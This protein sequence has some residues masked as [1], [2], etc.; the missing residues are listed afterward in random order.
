M[1]KSDSFSKFVRTYG[2]DETKA[3]QL[4]AEAG[5]TD[6]PHQ[7]PG[8]FDHAAVARRFGLQPATPLRERAQQL[9]TG[10]NP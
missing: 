1:K 7:R 6:A 4:L 5:V 3:R 2:L 10:M 9:Y 8:E